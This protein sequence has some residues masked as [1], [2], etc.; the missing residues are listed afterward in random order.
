MLPCPLVG[1]KLTV[2]DSLKPVA[3]EAVRSYRK[4]RTGVPLVHDQLRKIKQE[5]GGQLTLTQIV[6]DES[7]ENDNYF[8]PAGLKG[9]GK[10]AVETRD[11][12][13]GSF[14]GHIAVI[15]DYN[16]LKELET[17]N[18]KLLAIAA[19]LRIRGFKL[20]RQ[21]DGKGTACRRGHPERRGK[22]HP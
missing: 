13:F 20:H 1:P 18:R 14:T 4:I 21:D 9:R 8:G 5:Y 11:H 2:L 3:L 17:M 7:N 6:R 16:P 22:E 19:Q 15:K 12:T 10:D